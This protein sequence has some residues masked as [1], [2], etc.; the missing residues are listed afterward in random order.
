MI[1]QLGNLLQR[2]RN[3]KMLAKLSDKKLMFQKPEEIKS[4]DQAMHQS[5]SDLP[6]LSQCSS[7]IAGLIPSLVALYRK[8]MDDFQPGKALQAVMETLSEVT[9]N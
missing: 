9:I 8:H 4:E 1:G 5:L 2:I 3:D 7:T 6:G